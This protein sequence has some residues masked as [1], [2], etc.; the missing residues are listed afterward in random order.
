MDGGY[1]EAIKHISP[2][3]SRIVTKLHEYFEAKEKARAVRFEL[4]ELAVHLG[5]DSRAARD[6]SGS[7]DFLDG[8]L[9]AQ[10][11]IPKYRIDQREQ[12]EVQS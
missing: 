12:K 8:W 7:T 11:H 1:P 5:M 3:A 4:V 2:E 6:G 9:V 10:G